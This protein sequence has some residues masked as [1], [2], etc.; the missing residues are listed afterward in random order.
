MVYAIL[1]EELKAKDGVHALNLVT[2]T[3]EEYRK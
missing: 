3:A 2:K 1:D